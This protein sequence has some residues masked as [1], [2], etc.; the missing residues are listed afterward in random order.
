MYGLRTRGIDDGAEPYGSLEAMA[1]DYVDALRTVQ[2]Q[3]PYALGGFCL[4]GTVA[5]ELAQQLEAAGESVS[6]LVL[7]D[8]R[9]PRPRGLRYSAWLVPRRLRQ[10]SLRRALIGRI[11]RGRAQPETARSWMSELERVIARLREAYEPKRYLNPAVVIL[12]D[13]YSQYELPSWYLRRIVPRT[14]TTQLHVGH[15]SMLRPVGVDM[16]AR[17]VRRALGLAGD[18]SR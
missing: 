15:E 13:D 7:V 1:G 10:R 4:G 16:L 11:R 5:L 8:P 6:V 9:L 3:G 14:R 2:P 12:S 18:P 17:E